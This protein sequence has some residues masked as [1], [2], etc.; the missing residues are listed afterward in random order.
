MKPK[1]SRSVEGGAK[2][3]PPLSGWAE[4]TPHIINRVQADGPLSQTTGRAPMDESPNVKGSP[5][6]LVSD[7]IISIQPPIFP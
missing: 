5:L 7:Q 2:R 4:P 3:A 6:L 1:Q